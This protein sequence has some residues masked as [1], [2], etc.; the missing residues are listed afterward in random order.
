MCFFFKVTKV[1]STV[2]NAALKS[3]R[4]DVNVYI[5]S[6]SNSNAVYMHIEYRV[7]VQAYTLDSVTLSKYDIIAEIFQKK[8]SSLH[9]PLDVHLSWCSFVS[10]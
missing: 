1:R 5:S 9:L 10:P 2:S 3:S 6:V 4:N 7:N 8:K